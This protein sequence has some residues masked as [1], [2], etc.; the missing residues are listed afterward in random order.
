MINAQCSKYDNF[1]NAFCCKRHPWQTKNWIV[2]IDYEGNN[3]LVGKI[4]QGRVASCLNVHFFF[5]QPLWHAS[6]KISDYKP[7]C[8]EE[9]SYLSKRQKWMKAAQTKTKI[10]FASSS[11]NANK[12]STKN[13]KESMQTLTYQWLHAAEPQWETAV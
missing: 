10:H 1:L 2:K 7:E 13:N 3:F 9:S 8:R 6:N 12:H 11:I 5:Y 4:S